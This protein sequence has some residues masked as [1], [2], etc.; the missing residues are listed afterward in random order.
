[1]VNRYSIAKSLSLFALVSFVACGDS[2]TSPSRQPD[3]TASVSIVPNDAAPTGQET[4][5]ETPAS[6]SAS[7]LPG[8]FGSR[9]HAGWNPNG[10][11]RLEDIGERPLVMLTNLPVGARLKT[12]YFFGPYVP[13][14]QLR[15][16]TSNERHNGNL[17]ETWPSPTMSNLEFDALA[18]SCLPVAFQVDATV[19]HPDGRQEQLAVGALFTRETAAPGCVPPPPPPP[20]LSGDCLNALDPMF[21]KLSVDGAF[22][23]VQFR[24]KP[25]YGGFPLWLS[26]WRFASNAV[27]APGMAGL[28]QEQIAKVSRYIEE[29]GEYWMS[30]PVDPTGQFDLTCTIP[31]DVLNAASV[32]AFERD[33][34]AYG[35]NEGQ[36][37]RYRV[38]ATG[39]AKQMVQLR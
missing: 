26:S 21:Y 34:L 36:G 14:S 24:V 30:V 9:I 25:G 4:G 38:F 20:P 15:E 17:I 31:P 2:P 29:P 1:M 22:A 12:A 35:Y 23:M 32:P 37:W 39:E 8:P 27:F 13:C 5:Q 3:A 11:S 33:L 16:V 28:P 10:C 19:V 7:A 18:A 6:P